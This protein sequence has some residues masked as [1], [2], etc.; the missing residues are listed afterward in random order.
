MT[1]PE[2]Q[3]KKI[4]T[5]HTV[6]ELRKM[7]QAYNLHNAIKGYAKMNKAGLVEAIMKHHKAIFGAKNKPKTPPPA[8]QTPVKEAP[9]QS[10]K[11]PTQPEPPKAKGKRRIQP[12]Q[13]EAPG[14]RGGLSDEKGL[15]A[16]QRSVLEKL[17][18]LEKKAAQMDAEMKSTAFY[19]SKTPKDKKEYV[20]KWN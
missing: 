7:V 9:S 13:V 6:V 14:I 18:R 1:K 19:T 20:D 5:L 17:Q 4:L 11:A 12:T 10:V 16:G 3:R 8:K 2:E 15:S